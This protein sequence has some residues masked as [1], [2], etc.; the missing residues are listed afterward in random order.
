MYLD[1]GKGLERLR[2]LAAQLS[3]TDLV[4]PAWGGDQDVFLVA[5]WSRGEQGAAW[6]GRW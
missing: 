2:P 3:G 6:A 1:D 4:R 5:E